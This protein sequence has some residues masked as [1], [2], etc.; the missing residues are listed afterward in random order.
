G[1]LHWPPDADGA[2]EIEKLVASLASDYGPALAKHPA[3]EDVD[4]LCKEV[5][6]PG[7]TLH[8]L[9]E[10]DAKTAGGKELDAPGALALRESLPEQA[11]HRT[12]EFLGAERRTLASE[13]FKALEK[14]RMDLWRAEVKNKINWE[15]FD[16][17][18]ESYTWFAL[19]ELAKGAQDAGLV[20]A[21][22]H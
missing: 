9:K 6:R 19:E 4:K 3:Q 2:A 18:T 5:A 21:A 10:K 13:V 15:L 20:S 8:A 1:I 12:A 16:Y 17:G 22:A 11:F 14:R 7:A